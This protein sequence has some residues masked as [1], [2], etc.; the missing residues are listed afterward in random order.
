MGAAGFRV[1]IKLVNLPD[2]KRNSIE[3]LESS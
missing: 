2:K 1:A 3:T